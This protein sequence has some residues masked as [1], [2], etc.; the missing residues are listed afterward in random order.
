[1]KCPY[2]QFHDSKVIDSR[3]K[4]NNR[5]IR[6]RRECLKCGKRF[7]TRE[8]VENSLLLVVKSNG[9]REPFDRTKLKQGVI[10]ACAKR[11]VTSDA[12]EQIVARTEGQLREN[13]KDEIEAHKIGNLVMTHIKAVDEVAYV[14]FASVYRKFRNK[15]EFIKELNALD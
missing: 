12:I 9:R 4:N 14:R 5:E 11:P 6:R 13:G 10:I 3:A 2:C 8:Q 15:I 1:M 7:T